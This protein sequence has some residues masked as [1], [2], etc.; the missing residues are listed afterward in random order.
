MVA[1][2][3]DEARPQH[4]DTVRS[5]R[6]GVVPSASMLTGGAVGVLWF[7]IPLTILIVAISSIPSVVGF[8]L[9]GVVFIYLVRGVE[10]VERIRSEAVFGFGIGIPPRKMSPYTGFQRWA[11]QLWLDV[12]SA[13]FWKSAAHHFL[14]LAY[15]MVAT[16]VALALVMFAFIGPAAATAIKNSDAKA[17]LW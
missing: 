2:T 7:W 15:D 12:S 11:H 9:G 5:G 3:L 10:R 17:G 8:V 14:R 6:I 4:D 1:M 16:G 13:R